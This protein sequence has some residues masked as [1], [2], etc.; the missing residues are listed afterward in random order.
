MKSKTKI[1][2]Q[3][4]RKTN[5]E[6]VRTIIEL[7]K[8]NSWLEIAGILSGPRRKNPNL[9]LEEINKSA[10]EG[11]KIVIPGKVLSQGEIDKKLKIIALDFSG[12]AIEKLLKSKTEFS[13]I[14]QELKENP[15]AKGIRILK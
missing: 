2:K 8:H 7:K 12:R 10:K 5:N 15:N 1:E 9:N 13:Y 14:N 6:L 11:E 4:K 3:L